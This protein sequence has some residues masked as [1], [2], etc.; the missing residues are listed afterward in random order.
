MRLS[1]WTV[2]SFGSFF[3]IGG[4]CSGT[5]GFGCCCAQAARTRATRSMR[6]MAAHYGAGSCE[7]LGYGVVEAFDAIV[8]GGGPAGSNCARTLVKGGLRVALLDAAKF[9]RVK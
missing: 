7:R 4:R 5:A 9:P 3:A 2:T 8:V 6:F 1:P